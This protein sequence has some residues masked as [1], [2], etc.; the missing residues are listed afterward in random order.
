MEKTVVLNDGNTKIYELLLKRNNETGEYA[1]SDFI[2]P[3]DRSISD[4]KREIRQ[5]VALYQMDKKVEELVRDAVAEKSLD[6]A[7]IAVRIAWV[8]DVKLPVLL[9]VGFYNK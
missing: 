1:Y 9:A 6:S 3:V 4:V 8:E 5:N 2:R 7:F